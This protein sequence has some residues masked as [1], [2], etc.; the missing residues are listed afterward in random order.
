MEEKITPERSDVQEDFDLESLRMNQDFT[1]LTEVKKEILSVPVRKP[2]NQWFIRVRPGEEWRL[3]ATLLIFKE[4]NETYLVHTSIASDLR[5]EV[6]PT[7]LLTSMNR[8]GVVFIWPVRLPRSD[9]RLDNWSTTSL[10]AAQIAEDHWVR[11]VPNMHLGAY[12]VHKATA[13]LDD[14]Q[15][16]DISFKKLMEIA[17]RGKI[18]SD[19]SHPALKRLRGEI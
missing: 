14:P 16:P 11:V 1:D 10:D 2:N 5:S 18:V 19:F 12:E 4:E 15:W 7:L 3:S 9:G 6:T 8:Q 13:N 17:F